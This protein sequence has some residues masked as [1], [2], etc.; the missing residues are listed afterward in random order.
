MKTEIALSQRTTTIKLG[1]LTDKRNQNEKFE[2][3]TA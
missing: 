2:F 3:E 1:D